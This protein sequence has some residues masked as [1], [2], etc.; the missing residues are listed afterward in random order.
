MAEYKTGVQV[1]YGFGL[2]FEATGKAPIIAKQIWA[3]LADAQA[4]VDSSTDTAT[5]GLILVV[6]KDSVAANN[7]VYRVV[8]AA[9]E[10]DNAKGQLV[11]LTEGGDLPDVDALIK[12]AVAALD[13]EKSGSDAG[14]TVKV[15]EVDGKISDVA[16]SHTKGAIAAGDTNLVDGATVKTYVDKA[17]NDAVGTS[18]KVKGCKDNYS[19]L[20]TTGNAVGDVWNIKN[21]FTI[22]GEG[23]YPAGSNV[24][25]VAEHK[26]GS[27]THAA[28]WDVLGG[29]YDLS[30]YKTKQDAVTVSGLAA[31]KTITAL[32]QDANGKITATAA[33]IQIAQSQVTGLDTALAG[34]VPT[35]RKVNDKAL[36]ADVTLTGED[37]KVDT[38]AGAKTVANAIS[39]LTTIAGNKANDS[40][41]LK[42]EQNNTVMSDTII[43][44]SSDVENYNSVKGLSV[45]NPDGQVNLYGDR[46]EVSDNSD[47]LKTTITNGRI[48]IGFAESG[49]TIG[50]DTDNNVLKVSAQNEDGTT[51][52]TRI[53]GV[54]TPTS[55]HD[56]VN[57][58]YVDTK[59]GAIDTGVVSVGNGKVA[60]T[61]AV[62]IVDAAVSEVSASGYLRVIEDEANNGFKIQAPASITKSFMKGYEIGTANQA[63]AKSDDMATAIG[64]LE[65][66][67]KQN[68]GALTWGTWE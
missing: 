66:R 17:V 63:V 48:S 18:F 39:D 20:P 24:V 59:V 21:E 55:N 44:V 14:T 5:A 50:L 34:K 54:D 12:A 15:T 43:E 4:Y 62:N 30:V 33:N 27:T 41:V 56:A 46:L 16:V 9:G 67:I 60:K 36:S 10:D 28:H 6:A 29:T 45:Q 35:T 57:K 25:W 8:K 11:K 7:G 13:A 68:E 42:K 22:E 47:V 64:K 1:N 26:D 38:K 2:S 52:N 51:G 32:S 19:D 61:G 40:E 37:V 23:K 65:Y 58:L 53:T 3:T 31:G 49:V